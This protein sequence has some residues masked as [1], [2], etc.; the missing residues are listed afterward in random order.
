MTVLNPPQDTRTYGRLNLAT[1]TPERT[2][3][4]NDRMRTATPSICIERAQIVTDSAKETE[5]Q[6]AVIRQAHA[7]KRVLERM[8]IFIDDGE[9]VVGNHGSRPRSAPLY[10]EFGEF[11]AKELDLMPTRRVDTLQISDEDRATLLE[12]IYPYWKNR[13][14][15]DITKGRLAPEITRV[16]E[17]PYRPFDPRSRSH[18]GYGH[19]LPHVENIIRNGFVSVEEDARTRLARLPIA[20]PDYTSKAEFYRAVLIVVEGIKTFQ[21]R[22]A[23]LAHD[24]ADS[25]PDPARR[26]ELLAIEQNCLQVPYGPARSFFEAAQSYWFTILIDYCSQNG[27]AISGGRFD[28]FMYPYLKHDL[29]RGTITVQQAQTMLEALWVKHMDVIKA[30]S[31]DAARNNG[32]FATTIAITLGGVDAE[33][34]DAVNPLSYMCLDAEEAVFNSE[35]NVSIRISSKNPDAFI[36]RVLEVLVHK[37]G[38]KEP[39]FNDGNIIKGLVER[40]GMTLADARNWAIVGCVEPTGQGNTMGR[41]NSCYFNLAKCLELALNDGRCPISG[42]QIGPHTGAFADMDR[43]E[44]LQK[45]YARQVDHFVELMVSALNTTETVQAEVTPHVYTSMLIDGCLESGHDCTDGGARYDGA[46]VNGVGLADVADSLEVIRALVFERKTVAPDRL[47]EALASDFPDRLFQQRLLNV[48]KYGNDDAQVDDL[49]A[50]VARQYSESVLRF[51]GSHGGRYLPGLFSLSSNTPLGRQVGALPSGRKAGQPL[52]DGGISPK[53]GMD[54]HGPTAVAKSVSSWN[55]ADAINGVTLNMKFLPSLL[56]TRDDRRA[57]ISLIRTYFDLGGY[58][59]QFNVLSGDTLRAAQKQPEKYRG[60]VVRVAGY[61]AFFVELDPDIQNEIIA[62][63]E[64]EV[65][66]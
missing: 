2:R 53:H 56:Q 28:Q 58:H 6:P 7:L 3:L 40:R 13:S 11:S 34:E 38:G 43:F 51:H 30:G 23:A 4:L 25:E 9:L 5:G 21:S 57:L 54:T 8:T 31:F 14:T 47:L 16:L 50:Y 29:D 41:T 62:R 27:S 24:L 22:Y 33:G 15:D 19:Y 63:T 45:A 59:I 36:D 1:M 32:G 17:S 49:V 55:H 18:S 52:A 39:F 60:L 48:P 20:D 35:P 10:P 26:D 66:S 64:Q 12:E 37:E 42:D 61:S 65:V 46:G 44:D